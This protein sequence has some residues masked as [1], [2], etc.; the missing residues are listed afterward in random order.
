MAKMIA[1]TFALILTVNWGEFH[2]SVAVKENY[3]ILPWWKSMTIYNVY[4]KSFKDSNGDG[5]GDFNGM[6]LY[7]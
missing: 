5:I 6:F 4:P 7:K 3:E 2:C 1:F